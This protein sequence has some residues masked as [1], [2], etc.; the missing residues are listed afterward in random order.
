MSLG[1]FQKAEEVNLEYCRAEDI[2]LVRR[3]TGGRAILHGREITYSFSAPN[4]PPFDGDLLM[5]YKLLGEAFLNGFC[6]AGLPVKWKGRREKGHVLSGSSLCFQSV[7]YGEITLCGR[8]VMGSAQKRWKEGFLQQGSIQLTLNYDGMIR[9]FTDVTREGIEKAM[10]GVLEIAPG[11]EEERLIA[12][13]IRSFA[14]RF[15]VTMEEG[16]LSVY[17]RSI[18]ERLVAV[19]YGADA[20]T[21]RR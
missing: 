3:P 5:T 19:K 17:E 4:R 11:I 13:I 18:A 12:E 14:E 20:W 15:G 7:S 9:A 10:V 21:F 2:P 16:E 1:A 8:K 6:R